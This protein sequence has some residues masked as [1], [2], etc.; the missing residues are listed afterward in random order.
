MRDLAKGIMG[1]GSIMNQIANGDN[2]LSAEEE[3]AEKTDIRPTPFW[4]LYTH[5]KALH[6]GWAEY[7]VTK[8]SLLLVL[9]GFQQKMHPG[10]YFLRS[11]T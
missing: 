10:R 4:Y 8:L 7:W 11:T 1:K 2:P 9:A 3:S 5:R 6:F